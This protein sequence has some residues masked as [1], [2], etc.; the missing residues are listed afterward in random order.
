MGDALRHYPNSEF[1]LMCFKKCNTRE[2]I[3]TFSLVMWFFCYLGHDHRTGCHFR[4]L[5]PSVQEVK[6]EQ[7]LSR[8]IQLKSFHT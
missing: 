1:V 6:A 4:I 5:A 7:L 8:Q 3:F 2:V